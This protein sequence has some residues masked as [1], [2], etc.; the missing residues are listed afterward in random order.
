M[1]THK[2][3]DLWKGAM[4]LVKDTY[5]ITADFPK[6]EV[7]GLTSQIRRAAVS[8]PANISEGSARKSTKEFRYFLRVAFGS[9]SELETLLLL[10]NDLDF[11]TA[12]NYKILHETIKLLTVQLSNL[13]KTLELKINNNSN[14][15]L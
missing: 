13:M 8:V 15:P 7:F 3:L 14:A 4:K 1:K 12:D 11:L 2:D 5:N 9:L 10:S 6:T